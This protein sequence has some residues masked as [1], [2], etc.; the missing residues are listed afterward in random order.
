MINVL[1]IFVNF[2]FVF[3][4]VITISELKIKFR[5]ICV[6]CIFSSFLAL[7]LLQNCLKE[8]CFCDKFVAKRALLSFFFCFFVITI[9]EKCAY[10]NSIKIRFFSVAN[11]LHQR[12][13]SSFQCRQTSD[14]LFT[15]QIF[16]HKILLFFSPKNICGRPLFFL[17]RGWKV[18][19]K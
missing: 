10:V 3:F 9:S 18:S 19:Q 13:F 8:N 15:T 16:F 1:G 2:F 7:S 14:L 6:Y 4:F 12:I 11:N 5:N 17:V